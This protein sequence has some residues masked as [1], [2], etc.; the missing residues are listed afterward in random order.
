MPKRAKLGQVNQLSI[1]EETKDGYILDCFYRDEDLET[2]V[3]F[4]SAFL[5]IKQAKKSHE[6]GDLIE[7]FLYIDRK[8]QLVATETIPKA[9]VGH[10]CD[11]E[12]VTIQKF[13]AFLDWG[14]DEDL[15]LPVSEQGYPVKEGLK[16]VV[17]IHVDNKYGRIIASTK[18]H[19]YFEEDAEGELKAGEAVDIM[20][21]TRSTMGYKAIINNRYIGLIYHNELGKP[22]RFGSTMKAWVKEVRSDG[23]VDLTITKLDKASRQTLD[24]EILS[25]LEDNGGSAPLSDKSSAFEISQTFNCSKNNFKKAIGRLYKQRKIV[26]E[27]KKISLAEKAD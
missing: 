21:A 14:L 3:S 22:L 23:R 26:I 20:I 15:L 6:V 4:E 12:V 24:D 25:Y 1:R 16:Y 10:C 5:P 17:Y 27:P 18:L 11:L 9:T 8:D 13:G 2:P 7:A 19:H